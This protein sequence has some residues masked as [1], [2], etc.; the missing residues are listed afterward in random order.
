MVSLSKKEQQLPA[1]LKDL[2]LEN[3]L[4]LRSLPANVHGTTSLR[5]LTIRDCP[6]LVS[7]PDSSFP[8]MLRGLVIW[9]CGLESLPKETININRSC[10]GICTSAD[11]MS[12]PH[13]QA[14]EHLPNGLHKLSSLDYLEINWCPLLEFFPEEGF[15]A[16]NL[17]KV[18]ITSC[19]NLR[20]LPSGMQNLTSF[21][22]LSISDVPGSSP[23]QKEDCRFDSL[24][25]L[26]VI[27]G[28]N[29]GLSSF[30][31]WMLP[32]GL[33]NLHLGKLPNLDFQTNWLQNLTLL[34][35]LKLRDCKKLR[36]SPVE[37]LPATLSR[38]E[39]QAPRTAVGERMGKY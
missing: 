35:D 1:E 36:S 20:A 7:F 25:K 19:K 24:R 23:C 3:C 9:Q 26:S 37:G 30:P 16:A 32:P 11:V 31:K 10:L 29:S 14:Q 38:L 6:E 22:E 34:E 27:G 15:P 33:T 2:E 12:Y 39:I 28:S 5:E 21:Q 13:S 4:S 8:P 17:R 18:R